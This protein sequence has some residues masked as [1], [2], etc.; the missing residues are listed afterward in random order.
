MR[1]TDPTTHRDR[2]EQ[3]VS[4]PVN[5]RQ[6]SHQKPNSTASRPVFGDHVPVMPMG[7]WPL[8]MHWGPPPIQASFDGSSDWVALFLSQMISYLDVYGCYSP[9]QWAMVVA[10]TAVLMGEA[11]DWVAGLHS[12]HARELVDVGLFLEAL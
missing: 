11:A 10:I 1:G 2:G 3:D 9:S 6:H 5:R 7:P 4:Q 8:H 12:D